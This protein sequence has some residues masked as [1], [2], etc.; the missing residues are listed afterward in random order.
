MASVTHLIDSLTRLPVFPAV[1]VKAMR[2]LTDPNASFG[3]LETLIKQDAS[4]SAALLKQGNSAAHGVAGRSLTLDQCL[5][6]LGIKQAIR[7]VSETAAGG[8]M[9]SAGDS[10]GLPKQQLWHGSLFGALLAEHLA[11]HSKLCEPSVAYLGGLLRDIGKLAVD[12]LTPASGVMWSDGRSLEDERE[13]IGADH[14]QLGGELAT[15]WNL[16][17]VII[18]CIRHHHDPSAAQADNAVVDIVHAADTLCISAGVGVGDDGLRYRLDPRVR[19]ALLPSAA[20]AA[21]A[22]DAAWNELIQLAP[23][24]APKGVCA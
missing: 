7:I 15:R 10:Y 12:A 1:A 16:P 22:T 23:E 11:K 13:S 6:R 24:L 17:P 8:L 3:S 21:A 5:S 9:T 14:T 4:L 18:S 19:A 2:L 20:I